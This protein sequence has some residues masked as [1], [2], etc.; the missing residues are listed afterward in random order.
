MESCVV[1]DILA[2]IRVSCCNGL[3]IRSRGHEVVVSHDVLVHSMLIAV[4]HLGDAWSLME[5]F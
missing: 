3:A 4:P 2:G 1:R 5:L